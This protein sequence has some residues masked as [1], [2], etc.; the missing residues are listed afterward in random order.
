MENKMNK[1]GGAAIVIA[2][3]CITGCSLIELRSPVVIH[4]G[5]K[6]S[7]EAAAPVETGPQAWSRLPLKK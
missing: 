3:C 5:Q 6:A 4:T 1:T 2:L 7:T